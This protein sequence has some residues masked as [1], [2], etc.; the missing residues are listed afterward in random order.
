M[1]HL[2][3]ACVADVILVAVFLVVAARY[4]RVPEKIVAL[5][6][7]QDRWA[8]RPPSARLGGNVIQ[9]HDMEGDDVSDEK[10][11]L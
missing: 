2:Q 9:R 10:E 8:S 4:R 3:W 1:T 7:Y 11:V 6:R 5:M